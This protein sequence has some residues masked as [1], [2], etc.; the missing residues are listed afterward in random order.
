MLRQEFPGRPF[1][2]E[3]TPQHLM[4]WYEP[5]D[6]A[7]VEDDP[8]EDYVEGNGVEIWRKGSDGR[9]VFCRATA[10]FTPPSI[11]E[12]FPAYRIMNCLACS[13]ISIHSTKVLRHL[14][15]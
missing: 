13:A 4:T 10:G 15:G 14:V 2:I 1:V 6:D 9:C 3:I 11:Y 5:I 12:E 8:W 7:P